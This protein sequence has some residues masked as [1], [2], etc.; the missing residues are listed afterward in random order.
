MKHNHCVLELIKI[1]DNRNEV[2]ISEDLLRLRHS[3][4]VKTEPILKMV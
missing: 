4:K 2:Q 3:S 1:T